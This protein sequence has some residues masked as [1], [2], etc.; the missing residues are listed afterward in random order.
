MDVKYDDVFRL[1]YGFR[2][3]PAPELTEEELD[4]LNEVF[5]RHLA[6]EL[7]MAGY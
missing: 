5:D 2:S 3:V 4:E 1:F 6:Y 7:Y